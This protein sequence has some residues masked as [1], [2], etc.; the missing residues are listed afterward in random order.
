MVSK[1]NYAT[2][3]LRHSQ[4]C[5]IMLKR[6]R[7][8]SIYIAM[9]CLSIGCDR[10]LSIKVMVVR[11][12]TQKTSD[13]EIIVGAEFAAESRTV[14]DVQCSVFADV[15]V[16]ETT[17]LGGRKGNL[18]SGT[19]LAPDS[20]KQFPGSL[21]VEFENK[22]YQKH[23]VTFRPS[24]PDNCFIIVVPQLQQKSKDPLQK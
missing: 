20:R 7:D 8:L 23:S 13:S 14:I 17:V 11:S 1:S 24:P 4:I 3:C 18:Y 19:I 5:I 12:N 2:L 22:T 6:Y 10:P 21:W 15:D 16:L 9:V